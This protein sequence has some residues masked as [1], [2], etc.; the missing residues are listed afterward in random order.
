MP[1][2][3]GSEPQPSTSQFP[4]FALQVRAKH[5]LT[6]A[7]LLRGKGYAPFA[8]LYQRRRQWSDRTKVVETP[9]FPGYLFCRLNLQDRLPVLKTPG[10][11]RIVGYGRVPEELEE[12]EINA[13]QA[14]VASGRPSQPWPYLQAGD[15]VQIESGA[16]RGLQGILL[17]VRGMHRLVLSVTLLQRSVAVQ[18]DPA[19]V[20]LLSSRMS[21]QMHTQIDTWISSKKNVSIMGQ[22]FSTTDP[23]VANGVRVSHSAT[24]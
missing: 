3:T 20:T 19:F 5:E 24:E 1:N 15:R 21:C 7:N 11:T 4:W 12:T 8:P 9:L 22:V 17:E 23:S 14:M 10:V 16:L 13:L 6:V 18:I 2:H